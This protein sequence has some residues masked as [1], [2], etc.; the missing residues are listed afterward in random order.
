MVYIKINSTG[1]SSCP[2]GLKLIYQLD[3]KHGRWYLNV[4]F[5]YSNL[6]ELHDNYDTIF[7]L[8]VLEKLETKTF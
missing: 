3:N 6:L 8:S 7:H 1:G 5:V 2:N 4:F